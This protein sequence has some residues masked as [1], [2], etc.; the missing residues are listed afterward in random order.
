MNDLKMTEA[1]NLLRSLCEFAFVL[2][3]YGTARFHSESDVDLA[4][5]YKR[6]H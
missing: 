3:S 5:F 2:G 1:I 6:R 4:V